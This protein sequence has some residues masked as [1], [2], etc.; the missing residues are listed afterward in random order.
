MG[1][2]PAGR[3][4]LDF[5]LFHPNRVMTADARAVHSRRMSKSDRLVKFLSD[6]SNTPMTNRRQGYRDRK[7]S[8][9]R[10]GIALGFLLGIA[11][12]VALWVYDRRASRLGEAT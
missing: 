6:V 2:S 1:S 4:N 10:R 5:P 3:A 9:W 12:S 11:S 8:M 7:A